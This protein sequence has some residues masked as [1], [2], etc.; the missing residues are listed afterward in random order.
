MRWLTY[1][2]FPVLSAALLAGCGP[3]DPLEETIDQTYAIEPNGTFSLTNVDGS[4]WI[5]GAHKPGV[6]VQAIKK[7]YS[8]ARLNA[9]AVNIDSKPNS[10]TISTVF[11]PSNKWSFADRSGTVD[12]IIVLPATCSIAHAD[13]KNG[14][15]LIAGVDTG[16]VNTSLENGRVYIENCFGDVDAKS[17]TGVLTLIYDWWDPRKFSGQ[18]RMADGNVFAAIPRN[19]SFRIHAETPGGK[20]GNDFAEKEKRTG[21]I[22]TKVDEVVG[23]SPNATINL[24]ADDGNIKIVETNP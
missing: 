6:Q 24:T 22:V 23:N 8:A 2:L 11:P 20:I 10:L 3:S 17:G 9:I 21:T 7:A 15:I 4:I 16:S 1:R 18:A 19:A 14:E 5:Y 12:Y 13:L